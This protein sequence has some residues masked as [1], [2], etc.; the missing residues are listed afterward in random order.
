MNII[1]RTRES[2]RTRLR[3]RALENAKKR[4]WV[5]GLQIPDLSPEEFEAVIKEEEDK[6]I[7]DMKIK[8]SLSVA[9]SAMGFNLFW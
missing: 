1:K 7:T 3:K 5:E 8:G 6:I 2:F 4:L 9:L